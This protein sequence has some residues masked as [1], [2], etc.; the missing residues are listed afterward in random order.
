MRES[1]SYLSD[2]EGTVGSEEALDRL[3]A[4]W[5]AV[6]AGGRT[7]F[8]ATGS[9]DPSFPDGQDGDRYAA[10]GTLCLEVTAEGPDWGYLDS[11]ADTALALAVDRFHHQDD[12]ASIRRTPIR[13]GSL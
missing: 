8:R 9:Y 2:F 11:L 5:A 13:E 1:K 3:P 4:D 6:V 10:R 12:L 7:V